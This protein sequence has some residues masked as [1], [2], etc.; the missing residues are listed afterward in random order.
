MTSRIEI[1]FF[2][3]SS[4]SEWEET[5]T[6]YP[7]AMISVRVEGLEPLSDYSIRAFQNWDD[8]SY[9][10]FIET[11][12]DAAGVIETDK[13][14]PKRGSYSK[15]DPDG[16]FWSMKRGDSET[17]P[18]ATNGFRFSLEKNGV[19]LK[20]A[21]LEVGVLYP[22]VR[23]MELTS[24][25]GIVGT[26][27]LPAASGARPAIITLGGSEG[28][29]ETGARYAAALANEGFVAL[30]IAYFAAPGLQPDLANIPLEYFE[31]AIRYLKSVPE[32]LP[33]QI[34][35]MGGSRGGELS[36]L[37][38]ATFPDIKAVVAQL[39]SPYR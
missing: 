13:A 16:L 6:Y 27:F 23:A 14:S 38:G 1:R 36:L 35:V 32:V 39:P 4:A 33:D 11:T 17:A 8:R 5:S 28:G 9:T 15:V 24:E 25:A 22:G 3:I 29:V 18:G 21:T 10:S 19:S 37:L 20:D 31:K 12:S 30:A 2:S 7:G 26:L 34:A